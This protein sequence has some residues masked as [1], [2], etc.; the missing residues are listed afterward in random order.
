MSS[1]FNRRNYGSDRSWRSNNQQDYERGDRGRRQGSYQED[2]NNRPHYNHQS[3][4]NHS[5][6]SRHNDRFKNWYD[7][8]RY[9]YHQSNHHQHNYHQHNQLSISNNSFN[10]SVHHQNST[11]HYHPSS[12]TKEPASSSVKSDST[13]Q[14]SSKNNENRAVSSSSFSS[15]S[16]LPADIPSSLCFNSSSS[17]TTIIND[18]NWNEFSLKQQFFSLVNEDEVANDYRWYHLL[19]RETDALRQLKNEAVEFASQMTIEA[20]Y[21]IYPEQKSKPDSD[22]DYSDEDSCFGDNIVKP[23]ESQWPY[24]RSFI[25]RF[26]NA[27]SYNIRV[28]HAFFLSSLGKGTSLNGCA[29][30]FTPAFKRWRSNFGLGESFSKLDKT[31][32]NKL[33]TAKGLIDSLLSKCKTESTNCGILHLATL[34]YLTKLH[35]IP[36]IKLKKANKSK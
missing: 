29:L 17:S 18:T 1:N 3:N 27:L 12:S 16:S 4:Y 11:N 15:N 34:M 35:S 22:F 21:R 36:N 25:K 2:R 26:L 19:F 10:H 32:V 31:K 9:S 14:P 5:S 30:P 24:P 13:K 7:G 28:D 23:S 33:T 8:E 6:N 20:L